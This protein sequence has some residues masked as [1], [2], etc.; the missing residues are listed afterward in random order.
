MFLSWEGLQTKIFRSDG[1]YSHNERLEG[2]DN[3]WWFRQGLQ[4]ASKFPLAYG[5]LDG[6]G[7]ATL[8]ERIRVSRYG[9]GH[10]RGIKSVQGFRTFNGYNT[11][12]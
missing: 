5:L 6:V 4:P 1:T 11:A 8:A 2:E 10:C 7:P 9:Y 12:N 3:S